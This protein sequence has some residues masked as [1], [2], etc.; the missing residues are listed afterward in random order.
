MMLRKPI[1]V[2]LPSLLVTT[3]TDNTEMMCNIV[4]I[5]KTMPVFKTVVPIVVVIVP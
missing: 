4:I 2:S 5:T 3:T 1:I